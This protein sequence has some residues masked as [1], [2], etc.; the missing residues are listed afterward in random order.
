MIFA[1]PPSETWFEL[2]YRKEWQCRWPGTKH[3]ACLKG[4]T[5]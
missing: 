3:A 1:E 4:I 5:S 2:E